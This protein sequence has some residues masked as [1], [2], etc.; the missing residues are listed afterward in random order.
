MLDG[1]LLGRNVEN[2]NGT[3]KVEESKDT[4]ATPPR[5]CSNTVHYD[6]ASP[7][8]T[9]F[10]SIFSTP[11]SPATSPERGTDAFS[12]TSATTIR[13][14]DEDWRPKEVTDV[15]PSEALSITE[16]AESS[17]SL[18]S[19]EP[20]SEEVTLVDEEKDTCVENSLHSPIKAVQMRDPDIAVRVFITSC[21][22]CI[23]AGL[24]CSRTPP[25]CSRCKRAGYG[26]DCLLRRRKLPTERTLGE[27]VDNQ[28]PVL[29]KAY[30]EHV[31]ISARKEA[32][33]QEVRPSCPP[34]ERVVGS[35]V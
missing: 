32:L 28:T 10:S 11:D 20:S 25:A 5:R 34:F 8:N 19:Y 15:A 17:D 7:T 21:Y 9:N 29:L 31:E 35:G 4:P 16:R 3:Y 26:A 30:R 23:L 1:D 14:D 2:A 6:E 13:D 27:M 12:D 24:P 22:Q 18:F 33:Y